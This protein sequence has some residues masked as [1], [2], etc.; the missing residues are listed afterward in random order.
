MHRKEGNKRRGRREIPSSTETQLECDDNRRP[1]GAIP[2]IKRRGRR[3]IRSSLKARQLDSDDHHRPEL[4]GDLTVGRDED[5]TDIESSPQTTTATETIAV[6]DAY[7]VTERRRAE[8]L[9]AVILDDEDLRFSNR[10]KMALL[11]AGTFV[12][13]AIVTIVSVLMTPSR[14]GSRSLAPPSTAPTTLLSSTGR[15]ADIMRE[16]MTHFDSSTLA[17]AL[18]NPNSP[19]Y[20]AAQWMA[21]QD[22]HPGTAD[23]V[24]PLNRT[25]MDVLQFRQR[26]AIVT[27][28]FAT[29]GDDRTDRCNFLTPSLHVC[30]WRCPWNLTYYAYFYGYDFVMTDSMGVNCGIHFNDS[31]PMFKADAVFDDLVLSL[32]LGK[33]ITTRLTVRCSDAFSLRVSLP[34]FLITVNNGLTNTIPEEIQGLDVLEVFYAAHVFLTGTLPLD[35]LA[36]TMPIKQPD[37]FAKQLGRDHYLTRLRVEM[38]PL[39]GTLSSALGVF[40]SLLELHVLHN[41]FTGTIPSTVELLTN[42]ERFFIDEALSGTIPSQIY[43]MSALRY[44]DL[45]YNELSGTIPEPEGTLPSLETLLLT[46]NMLTGSVPMGM[47]KFP[48]LSHLSISENSLSGA[49]PSSIGEL[50]NLL[51]LDIG[52]NRLTG[53]VMEQPFLYNL[54]ALQGLFINDNFFSGTIPTHVGLLTGLIGLTAARSDNQT[55]STTDEH[56]RRLTGTIPTEIGRVTLMEALALSGN[57]L[58]GSIPTEIGNLGSLRYID[59]VNNNL[60]GTYPTELGML[61]EVGM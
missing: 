21:E 33:W 39:S 42:M 35:A 6:V 56:G 27:I 36:K 11:V 26:Y 17:Q 43:A 57:L 53:K 25:S 55:D 47:G 45:S 22:E 3:G 28:Y 40:S 7:V 5:I 16:I 18:A 13:V 48:I 49:L 19:Q 1:A 8:V 60:S 24:F 34:R 52:S 20:R 2:P 61:S 4:P 9:D 37:V 15:F 31:H 30:D 54:S 32:E 59:L 10:Q 44:L 29:G 23:L 14:N 12:L 58:T 50:V 41:S 46:G 51:I 38:T